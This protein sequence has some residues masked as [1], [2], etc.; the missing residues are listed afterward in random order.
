[1]VLH[2]GYWSILDL[3]FVFV[4]GHAFAIVARW[5]GSLFAPTLGHAA[6]NV[7]MFLFWPAV[8]GQL[9]GSG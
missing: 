1:M 5:T 8:W 4:V 2:I 3:V 9:T 6:V 7:S